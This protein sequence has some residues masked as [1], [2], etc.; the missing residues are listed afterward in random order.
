[1]ETPKSAFYLSAQKIWRKVV[2]TD[3]SNPAELKLQLDFHKRL[4]S[5][6]QPGSYYYFIFNM[7]RSEFDFV[8][9]SITDVLGYTPEETTV[10]FIMNNIHPDDKP[11]FL[12]FEQ[13]VTEFYMSLPYE[14]IKSYKMQYDY[15]LRTSQ[16]KYVRV[17]QQMVQIDYDKDNFYRSLCMHT[18]ISHIKQEGTPSFSIIGLDDEPSYYNV[19]IAGEFRQSFDLFTKREREILKCIVEGSNSK[20]IADQL[21]ISLHTVSTHRKNI[22]SKANAQ[23]PVDLVS[24]AI[25]EGWV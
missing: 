16:N 24:K 2:D 8:S 15:R 1:M 17:L 5:I 12:K 20:Q 4:L 13:R 18:D 7:Y 14:K 3:G 10:M 11:Y 9:P 21:S 19:N 22:L 6:F 25:N 23:T